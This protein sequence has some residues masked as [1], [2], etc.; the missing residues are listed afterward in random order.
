MSLKI[1]DT[2]LIQYLGS[3]KALLLCLLVSF[4]LAFSASSQCT[5]DPLYTDSV[6]GVWPDTM[7]NFPPAIL[8]DPYFGQIDLIV[9]AG[10]GDIP[11]QS[12]NF[13]IDSGLVVDVVGLPAGLT[14]E[15]NSQTD[16]PC[17]FLPEMLGCAALVGTPTETGDFVLTITIRVY[18]TIFGTPTPQDQDFE[19]YRVVVTDPLGLPENLVVQNVSQNIPNP[20]TESTRIDYRLSESANVEFRVIDMLGQEVHKEIRQGYAGRN[21]FAYRPDNIQTGVYLYS[22]TTPDGSVTKRM[23][24]DRQ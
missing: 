6:F 14:F 11:G 18:V 21:S 5:P 15:C 3:M 22:I 13:P 23:V 4:G 1:D 24:Y 10:T 9:P 12:V 8:N 7:T 19:G 2:H 20:F 16:A 17:T